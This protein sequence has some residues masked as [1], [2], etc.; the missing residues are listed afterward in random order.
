MRSWGLLLLAA[1]LK[2]GVAHAQ[3]GAPVY[4][5]YDGKSADVAASSTVRRPTSMT[6]TSTEK[7]R[8]AR[9]RLLAEAASR[10]APS[11]RAVPAAR[12][13]AASLPVATPATSDGR[14]TPVAGSAASRPVATPPMPEGR[15]TL[16]TQ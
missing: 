5:A 9:A 11:A 10:K 6:L 1:F 15:D 7:I 16:S 13:E 2:T 4:P 14:G 8:D 12:A 3:A